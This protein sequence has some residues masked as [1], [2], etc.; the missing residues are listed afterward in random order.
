MLAE[1]GLLA[2]G[3]V[4]RGGAVLKQTRIASMALVVRQRAHA[5]PNFTPNA[6]TA[7]I[8]R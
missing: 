8:V 4:V 2:G 1:S 6:S 3:G 5:V 7:M